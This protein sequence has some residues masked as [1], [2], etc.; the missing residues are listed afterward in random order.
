MPPTAHPS[1]RTVRYGRVSDRD[2]GRAKM[3]REHA[4]T[5][6]AGGDTSR[7][8]YGFVSSNDFREVPTSR[9]S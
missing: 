6:D 7:A 9:Q 2:G 5:S 1:E 8:P 4:G 3:P